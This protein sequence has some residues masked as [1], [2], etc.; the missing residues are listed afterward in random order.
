MLLSS[1]FT[2]WMRNCVIRLSRYQKEKKKSEAA[3]KHYGS[4]RLPLLPCDS[5]GS[6]GLCLLIVFKL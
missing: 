2:L 5:A 3:V 1:G 6:V 4:L